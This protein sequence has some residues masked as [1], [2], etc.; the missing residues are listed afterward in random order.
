MAVSYMTSVN[1]SN[2]DPQIKNI[3]WGYEDELGAVAVGEWIIIP[4]NIKFVSTQLVFS[5]IATAKVQYTCSPLADIILG[6][7]IANNSVAGAVS[8]NQFEKFDTISAVRLN[9][10]AWTSGTVKLQIRSQ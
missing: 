2:Y 9:V 10:T 4:N 3:A 8:A 7:A 5:N 6:T 1:I